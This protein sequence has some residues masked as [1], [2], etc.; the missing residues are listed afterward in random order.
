MEQQVNRLFLNFFLFN[1]I[2]GVWR[3]KALEEIGGWLETTMVE[4]IAVRALLKG[5]KFVF[6]NA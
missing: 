6:L 5:W 1:G 3:I 2:A 4:D